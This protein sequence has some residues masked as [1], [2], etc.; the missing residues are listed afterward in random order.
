MPLAAAAIAWALA[1]SP[2]SA[3]KPAV[4]AALFFAESM[5]SVFFVASLHLPTRAAADEMFPAL[6]ALTQASQLSPPAGLPVAPAVPAGLVP[7]ELVGGLVVATAVVVGSVVA[8]GTAVVSSGGAVPSG[9][10]VVLAPD[11][12]GVLV[13]MGSGSTSSDGFMDWAATMAMAASR[14]APTAPSPM[15]SPLPPP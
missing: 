5:Q 4:R 15:T 13:G 11:A 9:A 2:P 1:Q 3:A 14:T 12:A 8:L 6:A 10:N 7:V